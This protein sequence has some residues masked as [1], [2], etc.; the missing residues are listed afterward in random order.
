MQYAIE[1]EHLSRRFGRTDAVSDLSLNVPAGCVFALVGPNGAGKTTTIKTLMNLLPPTSGRASVLGT[2]S[3][4][5]GPSA[6]RRIGYVSENQDLPAWMTVAD[7]MAYCAPFYPTWDTAFAAALARQL[8]VPLDKPIKRCSRGTRMKAALLVSLAYRPELLVMDEPFGG[9]D[10]LVREE[11]SS[12]IL[13][14]VGGERPWTVFV[15][16]HDIDEVERLADW[17]GT[18]NEGRLVFAEPVSSLIGR[19]R[20]VDVVVSEAATLP[21]GLP[22]SWLLPE[23]SGRAIRFVDTAYAESDLGPRVR[24]L[25]PLAVDISATP[26]SLRQIFITL[27]RT[28]RGQENR[29]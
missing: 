15:S 1:T 21:G 3:R 7:M 20:Q 25:F 12:G 2:D 8:G 26:M 23:I 28:F 22:V 19:F 17:V 24:A 10:A 4:K 29:A 5:L 6:L 27:A 11:F 16:S 13:E 14:A 9:L 18:I